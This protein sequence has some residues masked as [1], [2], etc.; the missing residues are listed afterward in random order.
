[1]NAG[2]AL[3]RSGSRSRTSTKKPYFPSVQFIPAK[4]LITNLWCCLGRTVAVIPCVRHIVCPPPL[5]LAEC[6][7]SLTNSRCAR[8]EWINLIEVSRRLRHCRAGC[9][10]RIFHEAF[11]QNTLRVTGL[12]TSPPESGR[13]LKSYKE[14]IHVSLLPFD[15][16]RLPVQLPEVD[17]LSASLYETLV[18]SLDNLACLVT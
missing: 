8:W 12:D 15:H 9:R 1:M 5:G 18:R 17:D 14:M 16:L 2:R 11:R 7:C 10:T 13:K 6:N 4:F 3:S